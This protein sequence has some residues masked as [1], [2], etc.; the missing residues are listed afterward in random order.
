MMPLPSVPNQ[1]IP[2]LSSRT[3]VTS[4]RGVWANVFFLS[5]MKLRPLLYVPS[6]MTP[7]LS[8]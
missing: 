5:Y 4:S 3:E 1:R 7:L 8:L 6:H 2:E